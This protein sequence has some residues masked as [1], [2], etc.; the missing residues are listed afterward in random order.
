MIESHQEWISPDEFEKLKELLE[1]VGVRDW[2]AEL[3]TPE[4]LAEHKANLQSI[5]RPIH[6][7]R[8]VAGD[9]DPHIS[10]L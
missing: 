9:G 8:H 2:T 3:L 4:E 5:V 1:G 10:S 7:V 6:R